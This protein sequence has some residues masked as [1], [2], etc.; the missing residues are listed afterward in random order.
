MLFPQYISGYVNTKI[1][2]SGGFCQIHSY[3]SVLLIP[4]SE[5][6]ICNL[7]IANSILLW[8][9]QFSAPSRSSLVSQSLLCTAKTLRSSAKIKG[10]ENIR[11]LGRLLINIQNG[12]GP[13]SDLCGTPLVISLNLYC[14]HAHIVV[15]L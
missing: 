5:F 12:S 10:S 11:T 13:R 1:F 4:T 7:S 8:I 15:D 3:Q 6:Q 2:D 14:P 9:I